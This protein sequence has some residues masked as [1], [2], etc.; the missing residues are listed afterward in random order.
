M[1]CLAQTCLLLVH[2]HCFG[3]IVSRFY[4]MYQG[5][6]Q[7]LQKVD[8]DDLLVLSAQVLEKHR[9]IAVS[10]SLSTHHPLCSKLAIKAFDAQQGCWLAK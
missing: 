10:A 7:A 3:I 2:P 6:L 8:F 1:V 9:G 5:L 4:K